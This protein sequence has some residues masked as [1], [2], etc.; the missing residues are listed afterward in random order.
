MN[1][2][3][4]YI[5]FWYNDIPYFIKGDNYFNG[6]RFYLSDK[7]L[8]F[9]DCKKPISQYFQQNFDINTQLLIHRN[10]RRYYIKSKDIKSLFKNSHIVIP[11]LSVNM[12]LCKE[13]E[14]FNDME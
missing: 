14:P 6:Y 10:G 5:G 12:S 9:N 2:N 8:D 3:D 7:P 11:N 4:G 13:L 1:T